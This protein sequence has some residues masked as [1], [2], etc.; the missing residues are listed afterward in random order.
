MDLQGRGLPTKRRQVFRKGSGEF[1]S[2]CG[3]M[4]SRDV[5]ARTQGRPDYCAYRFRARSE[6][7]EGQ[8]GMYR[9]P[10]RRS[11]SVKSVICIAKEVGSIIGKEVV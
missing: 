1:V 4:R 5:W 2:N 10:G 6:F 11:W 3:P 8:W 7:G 9:K